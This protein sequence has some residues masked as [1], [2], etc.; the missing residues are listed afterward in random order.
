[1][2]SVLYDNF[3]KQVLRDLTWKDALLDLLLVNRADL[4]SKVEIGAHLGHN[5][6]KVIE[7]EISVDRRKSASETSTLLMRRA[8]F[9]LL[10][11]LVNKIPWENVFAGAG[12]HQCWSLF[13]HHLL[14]AQEHQFP[15][16][17]S[18]ADDGPGGSQC[19]E[20]EDHDYENDQLLVSPET[21]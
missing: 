10:R 12:V 3:M 14:K 21:V 17:G 20:L 4:M 1:M 19:P 6:Y 8:D 5:N 18:Q 16:A 2:N 15:N 11:E 13:K 7:F 9:R